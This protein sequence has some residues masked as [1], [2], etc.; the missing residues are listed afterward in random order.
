VRAASL[1]DGRLKIETEDARPA[2]L[3]LIE[4][5]QTYAVPI[6]SLEMLEPHLESVFLHLTGKRLRD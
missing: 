5:C 3:E 2:L 1:K 6:L 4:V